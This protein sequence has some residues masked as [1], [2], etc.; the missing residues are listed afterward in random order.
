VDS[1]VR[2]KVTVGDI[3]GDAVGVAEDVIFVA[4]DLGLVEILIVGV[5]VMPGVFVALVCSVGVLVFAVVAVR[6]EIC[7]VRELAAS[8]P[9]F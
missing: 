4:D 7:A 6:V 8:G 3:E 5:C 2:L 1:G 9:V